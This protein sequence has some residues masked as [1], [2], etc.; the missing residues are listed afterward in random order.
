MELTQQ[1]KIAIQYRSGEA[2]NGIT[3]NTEQAMTQNA[4]R[5]EIGIVRVFMLCLVILDYVNI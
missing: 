4:W 2:Q 1:D 3:V 5:M